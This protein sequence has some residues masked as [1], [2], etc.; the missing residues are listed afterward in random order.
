MPTRLTRKAARKGST[1]SGSQ[2]NSHS[3]LCPTPDSCAY[4]KPYSLENLLQQIQQD[5]DHLTL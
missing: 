4:V 2:P 1:E 3:M 5:A